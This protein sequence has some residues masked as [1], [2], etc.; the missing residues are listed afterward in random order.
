MK[1]MAASGLH[2]VV[3]DE[4]RGPIEVENVLD[5]FVTRVSIGL[6]P[7]ARSLS[8][9]TCPFWR[10]VVSWN[11]S[12]ESMREWGSQG[13][14]RRLRRPHVS[15]NAESADQGWNDDA[16]AVQTDGRTGGGPTGR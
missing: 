8:K 4:S 3:R 10:I 2:S 15:Q 12:P 9:K 7:Y 1:A 5:D 6:E 16:S 13:Q 11:V 14:V